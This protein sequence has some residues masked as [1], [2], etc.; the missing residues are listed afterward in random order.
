[1]LTLEKPKQLLYLFSIKCKENVISKLKQD[2]SRISEYVLKSLECQSILEDSCTLI[3]NNE[4]L[5]DLF[6]YVID[7]AE[8]ANG[9]IYDAEN[10]HSFTKN[11][12]HSNFVINQMKQNIG[13]FY[14]YKIDDVYLYFL[15]TS[16]YSQITQMLI[17]AKDLEDYKAI[18]NDLSLLF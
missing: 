2:N 14:Y 17:C 13:F 11:V 1:M 12:Q 16:Y 18:N 10:I 6:S 7:V 3:T 8:T 4:L 15:P 5:K 9:K